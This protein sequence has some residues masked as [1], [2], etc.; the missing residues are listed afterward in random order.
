VVS[1]DL[2]ESLRRILLP[3]HAN[4][5]RASAIS[6]EVAAARGYW[7]ATD[8]QELARLGFAGSQQLVPAL[9]VP[10]RGAAGVVV[11]HQVRPDRP[12]ALHGKLVKYETAARSR[13]HLDVPSGVRDLIHDAGKPLIVTEGIR[14]ADSAATR[15]ICV[16]GLVGVW[17]WRGRDGMGRKAPLAEWE[18]IRVGGREVH[19]AFDSDLRTKPEVRA[20]AEHLAEFLKD[21]GAI[22]R[23]VCLPD[24]PNGTKVGL[25]DFFAA[26]HGADDFFA[27]PVVPPAERSNAS[28]FT[29]HHTTGT[30]EVKL[31]EWRGS[32][33][34]TMDISPVPA[35]LPLLGRGDIVIKGCSHVLS[36][37]PKSGKS[38]LLL[39]AI[40]DWLGSGLSIVY[41]TEEGKEQW[42]R[43]AQR[44]EGDWSNVVFIPAL[45]SG[46]EDVVIV[47]TIRSALHFKDETD[48]SEVARKVNPWVNGVSRER[49]K[50]LILVHHSR[51]GGGSHGEGISG[52]HA[53]LGA[54]DVAIEIDRDPS[55]SGNRRVIRTLGR[56]TCPPDFVY[57][58]DIESGRLTPLG[59][60]KQLRADEVG[61]RVLDIVRE[62][63][64]WLTT[65]EVRSHLGSPSPSDE[66]VRRAL[67]ELATRGEI[68]RDPPIAVGSAQGKACK[69]R[70]AVPTEALDFTSN[71]DAPTGGSKLPSESNSRERVK[72][73][74]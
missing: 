73:V 30:R 14:K 43:R 1:T 23:I 35:S 33:L 17:G 46:T 40:S 55:N 21:C 74:I 41:Y 53:L 58:M 6:D 31:E 9:V 26:G 45:G 61:S 44:A 22:V 25:D 29:S 62:G 2:E 39:S 42:V 5:I 69:W 48:N 52:A 56:V 15:G 34:M 70:A 60:S 32:D 27:L 57:E 10:I 19:I 36:G 50:T 28:D 24:G 11:A 68:D 51:K 12:R 20:A 7:S 38:T 37:Y 13:I 65:Y 47:D 71:G 49:S 64:E 72:V 63:T 67:T 4:L 66:Q 3:H 54:V 8:R 16:V 18:D 59:E